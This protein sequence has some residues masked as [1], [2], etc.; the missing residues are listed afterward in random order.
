MLKGGL[1][2]EAAKRKQLANIAAGIKYSK[3]TVNNA[4]NG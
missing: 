4:T 2:K 1:Q 3:N